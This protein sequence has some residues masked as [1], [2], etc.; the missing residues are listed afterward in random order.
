MTSKPQ[1][2]SEPTL[3]IIISIWFLISCQ[4]F[5]MLNSPI[6]A[7]LRALTLSLAIASI[8]WAQVVYLT[9]R[10]Q[11]ATREDNDKIKRFS[12]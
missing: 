12:E 1:S 6:G 7:L 5:E 11:K 4:I 9:A 2:S 8:T 3:F 10:K